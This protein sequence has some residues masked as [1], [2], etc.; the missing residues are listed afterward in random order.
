VPNQPGVV[1]TGLPPEALQVR[2]VNIVTRDAVGNTATPSSRWRRT[3]YRLR[4]FS[5]Q[6]T[7]AAGVICAG[8]R[9]HALLR[10]DLQRQSPAGH[11]SASSALRGPF[12]VR[13]SAQ[14]EQPGRRRGGDGRHE[15]KFHVRSSVWPTASR[16]R[17]R[18]SRYHGS[19]DRVPTASGPSRSPLRPAP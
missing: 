15:G 7:C 3:S 14:S 9:D 17:S 13:R 16:R 4:H 19:R 10:L 18:S 12:P 6:H 11:S 2:T 1:D 5:R 8:R